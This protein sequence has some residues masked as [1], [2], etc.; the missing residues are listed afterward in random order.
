MVVDVTIQNQRREIQTE[1]YRYYEGLSGAELQRNV[2]SIVPLNGLPLSVT[3]INND[4]KITY[5]FERQLLPYKPKPWAMRHGLSKAAFDKANRKFT[6]Q[7]L[8]LIHSSTLKMKNSTVMTGIWHTYKKGSLEGSN[9]T[10]F[11]NASLR[12]LSE[13]VKNIKKDSR[14]PI[15]IINGKGGTYTIVTRKGTSL[16]SP[17]DFRLFRELHDPK[18]NIFNS[19]QHLRARYMLRSFSFDTDKK[20]KWK[21]YYRW[22]K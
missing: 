13:V 17:D 10:R 19:Q 15:S 18:R 7:G 1:N 4:G 6:S 9:T 3:T 12:N 14:V 5:N 8:N 16:G 2:D 20:Y 22:P 11:Y 21:I